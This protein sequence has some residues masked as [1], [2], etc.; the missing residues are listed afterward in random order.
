MHGV[1]VL[2]HSSSFPLNVLG[3][4]VVVEIVFHFRVSGILCVGVLHNILL[5]QGEVKESLPCVQ[6]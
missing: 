2:V 3:L 1:G 5:Y 6:I 4:P